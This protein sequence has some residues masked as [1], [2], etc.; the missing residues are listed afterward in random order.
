VTSRREIP[1]QLRDGP[2]TTADLVAAGLGLGVTR[3]LAVSRITRGVH[4]AGGLDATLVLKG[5][6][7][8]LPPG[9]AFSC[10]TAAR[11]WSLPTARVDGQTVHIRTTDQVRRAGVVAHVGPLGDTTRH[12]DLPVTTP[13][14]T[15][16]DLAAHLDDRWLLAVGDTIV[17]R[18]LGKRPELVAA[19]ARSVRRRGST[20]ARRV[21]ALV[22]A[23]V[24]SPMES[25][26]RHLLLSSGLP[27]PMVNANVHDCHGGWIARPDLSYPERRIAIEY[28]GRHHFD[29]RRQW[30]NDIARRHNLEDEGWVVRIATA[31]DVFVQADRFGADMLTLWRRRR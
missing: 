20:R 1:R 19:A 10:E 6:L 27:E 26:L 5:L 16:L 22:R 15:F 30:Q 7:L 12:D 8:V 23:D 24:D 17:R 13:I 31:R 25:L 18:G 11:I 29:D 21:S 28:D 14:E 3:R 2:F 4:V 9:S